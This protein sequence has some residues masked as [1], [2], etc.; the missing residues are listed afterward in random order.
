MA[1]PQSYTRIEETTEDEYFRFD[2]ATPGRWEYRRGTIRAMSGGTDDHNAI[3]SNIARVLGNLLVPR[4]CRVYAADMKVHTGDGINTY[5]DV[6][7]VCGPRQY[8][9]GRTDIIVNPLLIVEVLSDSTQSYDQGEKW[10]HYQTIPTLQDYLLV[11]QDEA[12]VLL[13][14]RGNE[15]WTSQEAAGLVATVY[16]PSVGAAL[17]LADVHTPTEF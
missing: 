12:R 2:D 5:P 4:G 16:L 13:Y 3:V 11:A 10:E 7:V 14:S 17:S 9:Q 6:A 1:L 15:M 8:H